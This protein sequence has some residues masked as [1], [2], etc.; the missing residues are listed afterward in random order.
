MGTLSEDLV[1]IKQVEDTLT[2][3]KVA[4]FAYT[5]QAYQDNDADGVTVY[6]VDNPQNIP[7]ATPAVLAVNE[8]ILAKGWRSQASSIPRMLL[9]HFLGRC[10]YNLNKI[11][12]I[13]DS[14]LVTL[15]AHLGTAD[16][17]ATLDST[18]KL[19]SAQIPVSVVQSV[20]SHSPTNGNVNIDKADVGLSNVVNTGDSATPAQGG[21]EKFTTGGAYILES[22]ISGN[23]QNHINNTANPHQVSKAQIGLSNVVNTGDSATPVQGGTEK[24][25]TGGAYNIVQNLGVNSPMGLSC[26]HATVNDTR[27]SVTL[28]K[29]CDF[30]LCVVHIVNPYSEQVR[31]GFEIVGSDGEWHNARVVASNL[32]VIFQK[33]IPA[34]SSLTIVGYFYK[35]TGGEDVDRACSLANVKALS[36]YSSI[37]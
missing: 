33:F 24:F 30:G 29:G 13:M 9:N 36:I 10:S 19:P 21:T 4:T 11:V 37:H 8:T 27:F 28:S 14:L 17:I 5:E 26:I 1:A 3:N 6:N 32:G 31:V 12:D 20:N 2:P 34:N 23:L 22:N 15:T 18:G 35:D 25:T 16:G 7:V